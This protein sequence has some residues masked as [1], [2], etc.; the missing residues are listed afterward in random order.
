M[1]GVRQEAQIDTVIPRGVTNKGGSAEIGG[2]VGLKRGGGAE[3]R[4]TGV[5]HE[6]ASITAPSRANQVSQRGGDLAK[7]QA[8]TF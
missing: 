7:P 3:G 1:P 5:E 6:T 2:S 8:G 4:D